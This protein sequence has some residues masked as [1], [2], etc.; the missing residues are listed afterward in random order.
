MKDLK[1]KF[2]IKTPF[3]RIFLKTK[4]GEILNTKFAPKNH[5]N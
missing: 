3:S 4:F 5:A 2:S 1:S